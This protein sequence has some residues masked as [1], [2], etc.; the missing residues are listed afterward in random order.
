MN[1]ELYKIVDAKGTSHYLTRLS[2]SSS[3]GILTVD[4]LIDEYGNEISFKNRVCFLADFCANN[5]FNL[6]ESEIEL[7]DEKIDWYGV[8]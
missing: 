4:G 7:N 3:Y 5:G 2:D 6:Y 1:I 8:V